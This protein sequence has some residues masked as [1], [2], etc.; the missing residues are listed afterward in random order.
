LIVIIL[1]LAESYLFVGGILGCWLFA[2]QLI[3]PVIRG[4][5]FLLSS[6]A[7]QG[8]RSKAVILALGSVSG[9]VLAVMLIPIALTTNVE[10]IVWVPNQA[11]VFTTNEGFVSEVFVEPGSEVVPGTPLLRLHNPEQE[12]QAVILRARQDELHIK[13]NAKR[14]TD[15]VESKILEE[16]LATVD[17]ELAQLEKRLESLLLGGVVAGKFILSD[18]FVLPGALFTSGPVN[19]L[20]R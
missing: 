8:R 20:Y 11:H 10:G 1:F 17:A 5:H 9:L 6:S 12:T 4:L 3:K 7:L 16:E 2:T 19:R 15:K 13:I 18:I 14:L